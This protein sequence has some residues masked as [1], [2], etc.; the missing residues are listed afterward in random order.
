MT[1][2]VLASKSRSRAEI[3]AAAGVPFAL[4]AS[5]VDEERAKA[6]L[7]KG[8]AGPR[9]IAAAL[10]L[11]KAQA[12]ARRRPGSLVIGADQTLDLGG[13]LHDKVASLDEARLR[14][15]ALRGR[16]HV[17]HAATAVVR[18]GTILWTGLESPALRMRP[19]S[20][21]YLEGYLS[22]HGE[23]LLSSVG[24]YLLEGEGIQLFDL[25]DGDY[26][27]VLGLPL[28]PLLAF[29]RDEGALPA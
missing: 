10:A 16:P 18:D 11:A 7:L 27:A 19:F 2:I 3:L 21:D 29:L 26:F 9:E 17:L 4:E 22:R 8:G 28:L 24:C 12:V 23:A 20:D 14:L 13:A 5:G 15:R 6:D 25:I 1:P